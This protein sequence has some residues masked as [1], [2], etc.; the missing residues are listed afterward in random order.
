MRVVSASRCGA[1]GRRLVRWARTRYRALAILSRFD[2]HSA[3]D[4][5][6]A[7]HRILDAD[8]YD[9][10]TERIHGTSEDNYFHLMVDCALSRAIARAQHRREMPREVLVDDTEESLIRAP[11]HVG[12]QLQSSG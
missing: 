3:Q 1:R 7:N 10:G 6:H 8:S 4:D 2:H 5:N 11:A 12:N 9:S